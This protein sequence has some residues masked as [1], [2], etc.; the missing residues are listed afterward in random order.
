MRL[1]AK[2]KVFDTDDEGYLVVPQTWSPAFAKDS[3]RRD[4]LNL[5]AD[6]W[7]V[8]NFLRHYYQNYGTIPTFSVM[9]KAISK[10]S[11]DPK[12]T[13]KHLYSLF[14][15]RQAT[16]VYRYAGLPKPDFGACA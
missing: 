7:T 9:H 1:S 13:R 5:G 8:I 3:A 14:P 6:H 16:K 11:P 4:G 2:D 10:T 12:W 15:T